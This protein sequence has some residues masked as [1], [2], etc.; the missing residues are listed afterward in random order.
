MSEQP[1]PQFITCH[2]CN[3]AG[4]NERGLACPNCGG[5]GLGAFE[6]G[7]FFYWGLKLNKAAIKLNR[8][9]RK[10]DMAINLGV[11]IVG[12]GGLLALFWWL[13]Q[14]G[15]ECDWQIWRCVGDFSF[16]RVKSPLLL[17][18]WLSV[19]ADMFVVYRTSE[20]AAGNRRIPP[21][22]LIKGMSKRAVP[23]GQADIPDNWQSL[24]KS[25]LKI[26]VSKGFGREAVKTVE[27]AYLLV[28][29]LKQPSVKPAHLFFSSLPDRTVGAIFFRL[30]ANGSLLIDRIKFDG[31]GKGGV[32]NISNTAKE[33]LISS[34]LEARALG[35][36]RVEPMNLL[37][38]AMEKDENLAEILYDMEIDKDKV[39]NCLQ[40]F[41]IDERMME[42]YRLYRKTAR[43]KPSSSMD[44]AYTAM[45]TPALNHFAYDLTRAAKW[46]RLELCIAREK[47]IAS[48][49]EQMEGGAAGV[50]LTGPAG[51]GKKTVAAGIAELMVKE[52]VPEIFKDKRLVEL[53]VARLI[54]GARPE[55]AEERLLVIL[56]GYS[57]GQRPD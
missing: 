4:E 6:D 53:D 22:R 28:E 51:V 52:E 56:D 30:E 38:P 7:K 42:N 50:I 34:Y 21:E 32:V 27:E 25:K 33:V 5:M 37:L 54:S 57:F 3:G 47:E 10:W 1:Q 14:S 16:W 12:V 43:F 44:R 24:K 48:V 11:Y 19:L 20:I 49:F 55:E 26:D 23:A 45:A 31:A 41:R 46:G 9:K 40:W 13:W 2:A 35:Q 15:G 36:K 8:L 29:N 18:F 39:A 17:F